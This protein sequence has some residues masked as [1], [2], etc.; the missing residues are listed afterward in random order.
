MNSHSSTWT[1]EQSSSSCLVGRRY[2]TIYVGLNDLGV[3]YRE[4]FE[5][6]GDRAAFFGAHGYG[7]VVVTIPHHGGHTH[8]GV[9][10]D[11]DGHQDL[12]AAERQITEEEMASFN[13]KRLLHNASSGAVA[14]SQAP[15]QDG[16]LVRSGLSNPRRRLVVPRPGRRGGLLSHQESHLRYRSVRNSYLSNLSR[17]RIVA[18]PKPPRGRSPLVRPAPG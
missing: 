14:G 17:C 1:T 13:W 6:R 7:V 10:G 5:S 8:G 9:D 11:S 18:R 2:K 12:P 4:V 16:L 15:S 3:S